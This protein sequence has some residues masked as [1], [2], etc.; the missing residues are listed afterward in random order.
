MA[1]VALRQGRGNIDRAG[2]LSK[3]VF[4]AFYLADLDHLATHA[5]GVVH[6]DKVISVS[7]CASCR[8]RIASIPWDNY[9]VLD[10][11]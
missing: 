8:P 4:V 1:L 11:A 2:E 3:T 5:K 9:R 7:G 6:V 10:Q